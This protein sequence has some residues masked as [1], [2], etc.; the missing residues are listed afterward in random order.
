MKLV[1]G[2]GNPGATYADTRHNVG[3]LVLDRL[4]EALS[5]APY[6]TDRRHRAEVTEARIGARRLLLVKPQTYMNLSGESVGALMRFWKL[7]PR[8]VLVVYDDLALPLGT[9]RIRP[10]GSAGGHNGIKSLLSHLGTASFD[11][12]RVGI[13]PQPPGV[14]SEVFVLG[15]WSPAERLLLP[16][17]VSLGLAATR[18]V[19]EEGVEWAMCRFN[20]TTR[21][22]PGGGSRERGEQ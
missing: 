18:G 15:R 11:R 20:G 8:D 4:A 13:G 21:P 1:V 3:W 10:D 16:E 14:K 7:M 17:A 5:A 22:A 6:R 19:I 2:L 12:V 9:V